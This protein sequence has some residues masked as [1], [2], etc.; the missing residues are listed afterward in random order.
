MQA[1]APNSD[2]NEAA[3]VAPEAFA[4]VIAIATFRRPEGLAR[5]L[6]SV[7][8]QRVPAGLRV[9]A[10]VVNNAADDRAPHAIAT[11]IAR[12]NGLAVTVVDEPRPGV[13]HARNRALAIARA[14]APFVAFLD[15]DEEAPAGWIAALLDGLARFD[16]EVAT[17]TVLSA[18][19]T[20]PPRWVRAGRFFDRPERATGARRPWAFTGNVLLRTAALARLGDDERA[21]FDPSFAQGEDRDFFT[22]L[23]RA[24]AR[25]VWVAEEPPVERVPPAR[26]TAAWL[27]ARM[28]GIGRST[29]RV[30][31]RVRGAR[32]VPLLLAKSAVWIAIGLAQSV[33]GLAVGRATRV[34]GRRSIA[35]GAGLA[36]GALAP[37]P[38]ASEAS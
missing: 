38:S 36:A 16:A 18:F 22:R 14:E 11:R 31:R 9:R 8:A 4:V 37:S 27:V 25:I 28:G 23:A 12:E 32:V 6:E 2:A 30:E 33:A 21:W 15:D 20:E 3:P 34:H 35:Y 13:A 5:A 24:G 29:A 26:T 19:E 7:A 17:G 10:L 1:N